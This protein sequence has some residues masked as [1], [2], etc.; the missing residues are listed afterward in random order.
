MKKGILVVLLTIA[1]LAGIWWLTEPKSGKDAAPP[2]ASVEPA[3]GAP[4]STATPTTTDAAQASVGPVTLL[5][6][7]GATGENRRWRFDGKTAMAPLETWAVAPEWSAL[8]YMSRAWGGNDLAAWRMKATGEVRLWKLSAASPEPAA[9]IL[10][11]ADASWQVVAFTDVNQD[12]FDDVVWLGRD[13]GVAVWTLRDGKVQE[14]AL[15]GNVGTGWSAAQVGDFD[16]DGRGD[17]FWIKDDGSSAS[18]WLL[19]GAKLKSA[20]AITYTGGDWSLVAAGKFDG[21]AGDDLLWRASDGRL[22]GWSS[23]D[24]GKQIAFTRQATGDWRFVAAL[25]VDGNG[26]ADLLWHNPKTGQV[27]AWLLAANGAITDRE[28]PSIGGEWAPVPTGLV[29]KADAARS[30]K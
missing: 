28:L 18:L 27:G 30:P 7:N 15:I 23:A 12:G 17:L 24:P 16:G 9:E 26:Y 6:R 29:A 10:P 22:Q 19:D 5:W 21:Q 1:A 14:Q 25:D 3:A 4:A 11:A 2:A 8:G 20:R 13:G